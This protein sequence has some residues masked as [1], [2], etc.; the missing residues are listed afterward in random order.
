MH[1]VIV[2][3]SPLP[4]AGELPLVMC[5]FL[6]SQTNLAQ[7]AANHIFYERFGQTEIRNRKICKL[8]C[9]YMIELC[10]IKLCERSKLCMAE[11]CKTELGAL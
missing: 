8:Y 6:T 2:A 5:A 1:S 11:L 10:E 7:R 3:M 4:W 9:K